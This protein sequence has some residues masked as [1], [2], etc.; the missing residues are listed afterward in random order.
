MS[1]SFYMDVHVPR[2]VT[3]QL[4]RRGIDV[5]TAHDDG[6]TLLEDEPLLERAAS[7]GR[8]LVTNDIR[9][10]ARAGN[11]QATG[12]HFA[13]LVFAHQLEITIGQL[14]KDL[15]L[16][17]HASLPGECENQIFRLPL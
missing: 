8:V 11:W 13:G 6:T 7:L 3:D 12:K 4:R 10:Y 14:V 9:F 17:S 15:E 1:A 2:V 5:L 16:I